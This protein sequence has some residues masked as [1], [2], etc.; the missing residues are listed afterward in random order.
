MIVLLLLPTRR[1]R[2][3]CK[4]GNGQHHAAQNSPHFITSGKTTCTRTRTTMPSHAALIR[5]LACFPT[6]AIEGLQAQINAIA[7]FHSPH[8]NHENA[9]NPRVFDVKPRKRLAKSR[10]LKKPVECHRVMPSESLKCP[11]L[12]LCC[13]LSFLLTVDSSYK[14]RPKTARRPA[15]RMLVP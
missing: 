11:V 12:F 13:C 8:R 4:R 10:L 3:G 1:H 9:S 15:A 6:N 5:S 14:A 7:G 2:L